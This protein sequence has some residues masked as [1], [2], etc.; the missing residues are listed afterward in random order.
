VILWKGLGFLWPIRVK[1]EHSPGFAVPR[2]E[3]GHT[4][5]VR[6]RGKDSRLQAGEPLEIQETILDG[7][8]ERKSTI[9]ESRGKKK[10]RTA[11]AVRRGTEE[12]RMGLFGEQRRS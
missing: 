10:P 3:P 9:G 6:I 5:Q 1:Y 7:W 11:R 8:M 2:R 12:E 4:L